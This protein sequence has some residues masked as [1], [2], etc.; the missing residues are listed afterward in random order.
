[1]LAAPVLAAPSLPVTK[2]P[3]LP[4]PSYTGPTIDPH[5]I[6]GQWF[7]DLTTTEESYR[8]HEFYDNV[9]GYGGSAFKSFLAIEGYVHNLSFDP[10]NNIVGFDVLASITNDTPEV[11]GVWDELDNLHGETTTTRLPYQ[12]TMFDTKLT[13][14]FADDG[15]QGNL[16]VGGV[17]LP[18]KNIF[19][20]DYDQ[21]GWYC[22]TPDNPDPNKVPWGGYIVPT[23]DFGDI[24]HFETVTRNL[25]FGLYTPVGVGSGLHTFLTDAELNDWD[26]FMNRTTS[27][28]I[29]QYI[30]NFLH[31]DG[32][33]YPAPPRNSDVSVFHNIIPLPS[34]GLAG[35]ALLGTLL[36]RRRRQA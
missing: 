33:P 15:I 35:T 29:S 30:D 23:Y 19:A 5:A 11:I 3:L 20:K 28:K 13:V 34:A 26:V 24:A 21:M 32:T 4:V 18:E 14:E 25:S 1:L 8:T 22:W 2:P 9:E 10:N 7:I 36:T 12:C 6:K 31:D 17:Y 16:P 27:L